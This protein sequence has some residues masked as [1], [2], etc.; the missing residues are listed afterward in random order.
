MSASNKMTRVRVMILIGLS[1]AVLISA[2]GFSERGLEAMGLKSLEASNQDYLE[3]SFDRSLRL[4]ALLSAVKVGLAVVEGSEV[5]VGFGLELGDIVQSSYDHV[6]IAWR[7]VLAAA[8]I[9][10][11]LRFLLDTADLLDHWFLTAALVF[12]LLMVLARWYTP[13]QTRA[14]RSCRDVGLLLTVL[15]VALYLLLPL[16]ISG[17]RWLSNRITAPSLERA[18]KGL[19]QMEKRLSYE[20][21]SADDGLLSGL[22]N[23]K[24]YL[25]RMGAY[26]KQ[27]AG[28][29][30]VLLLIIIA[31][32]IFD[33]V[34]FPLSLFL[35]LLWSTRLTARYLFG[36]KQA[37][38]FKEDLE[39]ILAKFHQRGAA[40]E[41][42]A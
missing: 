36:I 25:L 24:E 22:R 32:Y 9:L 17:G 1:A 18:E 12:I 20:E 21:G 26:L 28:D 10:Q 41:P 4:F 40:A 11:S 14:Q 23:T 37:Q 38:N 2:L 42:R 13:N 6:D 8:V 33:C 16:S 5:G 27:K 19:A 15:T 34:V 3:T 31:V 35:F 39:T 30:M 29:L 7:T